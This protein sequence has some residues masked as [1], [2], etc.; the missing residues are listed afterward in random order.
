MGLQ[1]LDNEASA[2]YKTAMKNIWNVEYKLV[3]P[4]LHCRNVSERAI[5]TFKTHLLSILAGTAEDF[6]QKYVV[7]SDYPNGND[8][9]SLT[10]INVE[11]YYFGIGTFQWAN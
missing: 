11:T 7:S 10:T 1:I 8:A 2:Y 3:P 4:N 6:P 5:W 9:Q